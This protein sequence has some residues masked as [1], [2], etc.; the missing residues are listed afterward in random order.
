MSVFLIHCFSDGFRVQFE[1]CLIALLDDRSFHG[2]RLLN[3]KLGGA[4]LGQDPFDMSSISFI[5]ERCDVAQDL[6]YVP[7]FTNILA[8]EVSDY[9]PGMQGIVDGTCSCHVHSNWINFSLLCI[10]DSRFSQPSKIYHSQ[11][12][13]V[14]GHLLIQGIY[15]R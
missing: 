2:Q 1:R 11:I 14:V 9:H 7:V 13:D 8:L 4:T 5:D 15:F 10:S 12:G 3:T 6:I